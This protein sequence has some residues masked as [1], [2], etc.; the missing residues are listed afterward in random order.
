[1]KNGDNKPRTPADVRAELTELVRQRA[2]KQAAVAAADSGIATES[3]AAFRKEAGAEK[4]AEN[5][6]NVV[7]CPMEH[8]GWPTHSVDSMMAVVSRLAGPEK[9]P[10]GNR[11]RRLICTDKVG[12]LG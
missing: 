6:I 3:L 2:E 11:E 7:R 9:L 1:M 8:I 10:S 4:R 12:D 5:A